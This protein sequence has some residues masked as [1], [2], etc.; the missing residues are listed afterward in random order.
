MMHR[1][2]IVLLK[3]A[4]KESIILKKKTCYNEYGRDIRPAKFIHQY[5][6]D[7]KKCC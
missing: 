4:T 5:N 3:N 2:K 7:T 6:V 1:K